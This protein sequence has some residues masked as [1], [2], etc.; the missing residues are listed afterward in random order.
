MI[1]RQLL[2]GAIEGRTA[3]QIMSGVASDKAYAAGEDL[4][5]DVF[6]NQTF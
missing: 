4:I 6:F 2:L 5:E 3:T 1:R